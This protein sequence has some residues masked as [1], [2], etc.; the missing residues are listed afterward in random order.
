MEIL[1]LIEEIVKQFMSITKFLHMI[2]LDMLLEGPAAR[3]FTQNI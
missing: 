3:K 1:T 2:F